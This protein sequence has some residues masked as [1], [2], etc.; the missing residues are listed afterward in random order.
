[1]MSLQPAD[2][3]A[4]ANVSSDTT[5]PATAPFTETAKEA[6]GSAPTNDAGMC[7]RTNKLTGRDTN[8]ASLAAASA[9][10]DTAAPNG[11]P[12]SSKKSNNK[13]KS[14]SEPKGKSLKK[15]QSMRELHL[16]ATPGQLWW[17]RMKGY[18]NWPAIVCDEDMLPATLLEKRPV[19]AARTDGSYR[20]DFMDGGKNARDRRYPVMFLGTNEL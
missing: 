16:D 5:D 9:K 13:R 7:H 18:P 6:T 1:M 4:A 10:E 15:K 11:T 8:E 20:E 17:V 14:I 2:P 3:S 19:S 12:S